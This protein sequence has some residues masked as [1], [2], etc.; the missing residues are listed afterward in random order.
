MVCSL[1]TSR[2]A[3]ATLVSDHFHQPG[4]KPRAREQPLPASLSPQP[5]AAASLLSVS[6]DLLVPGVPRKCSHAA[7]G[8]L[9]HPLSRLSVPSAR[10]RAPFVPLPCSSLSPDSAT[11]GSELLIVPVTY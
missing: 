2:A 6:M 9:Q 11:S 4:K 3:I 5:L 10:A 1:F 7:C 8:L